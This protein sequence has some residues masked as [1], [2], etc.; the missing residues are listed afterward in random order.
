MIEHENIVRSRTTV[1]MR[2]LPPS[3]TTF[4]PSISPFLSRSQTHIQQAYKNKKTKFKKS[5]SIARAHHHNSTRMAFE[6]G[7]GSK[8]NSK[9]AEHHALWFVTRL[10]FS[11]AFRDQIVGLH[12]FQLNTILFSCD[13]EYPR[14]RSWELPCT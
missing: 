12:F 8:I 1:A 5:L 11:M 9:K 4:F 7:H 3:P 10:L 6:C 2:L 14:P 13:V